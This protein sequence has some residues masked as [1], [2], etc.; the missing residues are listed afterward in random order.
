MLLT[1]APVNIYYNIYNLYLYQYQFFTL[2]VPGDISAGDDKCRVACGLWIR[3]QTLS[4]RKYLIPYD[5]YTLPCELLKKLTTLEE[6]LWEVLEK[7]KVYRPTSN[8]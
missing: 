1:H 7:Y 3:K 2:R 4:K 6:A 8:A 5:N